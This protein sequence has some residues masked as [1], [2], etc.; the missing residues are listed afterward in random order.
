MTL[1]YLCHFQ[2]T[3]PIAD[4]LLKGLF[5]RGESH[6][7]GHDNVVIQELRSFIWAGQDVSARLLIGNQLKP[8]C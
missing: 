3:F 2:F 8:H 7:L 5:K 1:A 4:S 6:A